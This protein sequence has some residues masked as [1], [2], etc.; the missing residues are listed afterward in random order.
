MTAPGEATGRDVVAEAARL[1]IGN[2][3][4][5][6][7]TIESVER[8]ARAYGFAVTVVPNWASLTLL[9]SEGVH[10]R[11][12]PVQP[13]A[14]H[15]GVVTAVLDTIA[16]TT[17]TTTPPSTG[18]V[19]ARLA[20]DA[21]RPASSTIAFAVAAATGASSLAV[22]FGA[23]RPSSFV[24][25]PMAAA[26]GAVL[27]R[28]LGRHGVALTGQAFAAAFIGGL[29]G[30]LS[31]HFD[32]SSPARLVA[33]CPAMVLVPGPHLLN[34]ALD[35]ASRRMTIGLGRL[36]Y[37]SH[38]TLGICAGLLLGL[39]GGGA[40]PV[41]T[42]GLSV[43]IALDVV[44]A[45]VAAASYPVYFSLDLR[46]VIWPA[47]AGALAHGVRWLALTYLNAGMVGGG[48]LACL[49]AG[50]LLVP[51]A[52]RFRVS[53]AG[54]GF[55]AVVALVPGVYIFRAV[56]GMYDLTV[57]ASAETA[58]AVGMDG[59]TALLT[60]IAMAVGLIVGSN[61][62]AASGWAGWSC[63]RP[64]AGTPRSRPRRPR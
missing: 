39:G 50:L 63:R 58:T 30:L 54:V 14:V 38:I 31:M 16:W 64:R 4:T 11:E 35:I 20:E 7:G 5:T 47:A 34:A 29:A 44:A 24:L 41:S 2:G 45:A 15:M 60:L 56:A 61:V 57:H 22:I 23:V 59:S 26:A 40:L 43:P 36:A 32:I 18:V 10:L 8:L 51:V 1:L 42:A 19:A 46:F 48:F 33:V 9:D 17:A 12:I 62:S 25:I 37:G 13:E 55:A 53:F 52:H 6:T 49:V 27:R 3:H 28:F 21:R